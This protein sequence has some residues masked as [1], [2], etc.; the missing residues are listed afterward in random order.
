MARV[1]NARL[2]CHLDPSREE[3][4]GPT[5]PKTNALIATQ[6]YNPYKGRRNDLI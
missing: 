6:S 4:L 2:P 1:N 5:A 3:N